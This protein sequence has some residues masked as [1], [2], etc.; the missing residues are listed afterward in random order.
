V[1]YLFSDGAHL[2]RVNLAGALWGLF[3][4]LSDPGAIQPVD[5][6]AEFRDPRVADA[7]LWGLVGLNGVGVAL[8]PLSNRN[9]AMAVRLPS[10]PFG[11]AADVD[12]LIRISSPRTLR[13]VSASSGLE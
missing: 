5:L 11:L 12:R 4:L 2:W 6:L 10:G 3:S 9:P 13:D 1:R 7:L 8:A